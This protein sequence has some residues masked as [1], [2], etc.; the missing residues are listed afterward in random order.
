MKTRSE[1]EIRSLWIEDSGLIGFL[2]SVS[3]EVERFN[4][5]FGFGLRLL[6]EPPGMIDGRDTNQLNTAF[7]IERKNPMLTERRYCLYALL[8]GRELAGYIGV[9]EGDEI[10]TLREVGRVADYSEPQ[11]SLY[12]WMRAL[13]KA[14]CD[15]I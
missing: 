9:I 1:Q 4:D 8:E 12:D 3:G 10:T 11:V 5:T 6:P 7:V 14:S 13:L 2:S 15:K